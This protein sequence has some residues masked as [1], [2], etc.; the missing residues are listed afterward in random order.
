[1]HPRIEFSPASN[2]AK[3]ESLILDMFLADLQWISWTDLLPTF[4]AYHSLLRCILPCTELVEKLPYFSCLVVTSPGSGLAG[5][6]PPGRRRQA[7]VGPARDL[8]SPPP[9]TELL[10]S[11]AVTGLVTS[12]A[13][14]GQP[15]AHHL[16]LPLSLCIQS[17][18]PGG[19]VSNHSPMAPSPT[20]RLLWP[21]KKR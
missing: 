1:M 12:S 9:V 11:S 14:S 20:G 8:W 3:E 10:T 15:A 18:E 6:L 7:V 5:G 17:T 2:K 19:F 21:L 16:E 4:F 13:R